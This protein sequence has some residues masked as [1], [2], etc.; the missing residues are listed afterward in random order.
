MRDMRE[1]EIKK[2]QEQL[3]QLDD[4]LK[5]SPPLFKAYDR[6]AE[7]L[8]YVNERIILERRRKERRKLMRSVENVLS[9]VIWWVRHRR[10]HRTEA[11]QI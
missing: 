8:G 9:Q 11:F 3:K 4:F 10:T 1:W 5:R 7:Q 2:F 6:L